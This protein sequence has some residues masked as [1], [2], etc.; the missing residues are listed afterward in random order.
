MNVS[1]ANV[2]TPVTY[3]DFGILAILGIFSV[4]AIALLHEIAIHSD[5]LLISRLVAFEE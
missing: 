1:G 3:E 5:D 4:H 2:P